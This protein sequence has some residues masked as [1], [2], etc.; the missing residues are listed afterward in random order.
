MWCRCVQCLQAQA[1]CRE[2]R[3][4]RGN[5]AYCT[6]P[7]PPNP[8][9]ACR[10]PHARRGQARQ[11]GDQAHPGGEHGE[12]DAAGGAR[13]WPLLGHVAGPTVPTPQTNLYFRWVLGRWWVLCASGAALP[14]AAVVV[15]AAGRRGLR[16]WHPGLGV[17]PRPPARRAPLCCSGS[18]IAILKHDTE[19]AAVALIH[20]ASAEAGQPAV[21]R[22]LP[23]PAPVGAAREA[24]CTARL[25]RCAVLLGGQRGAAGLTQR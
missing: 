9:P 7:G 15:A 2:A 21:L 14:A 10:R 8:T 16:E 11:A 23:A 24:G 1:P 25:A 5:L 3:R 20:A 22:A 4:P 18:N 12:G 13:R 6:H 17:T 19:A